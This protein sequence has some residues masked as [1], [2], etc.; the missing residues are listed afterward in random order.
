MV[1]NGFATN[2]LRNLYKKILGNE[3]QFLTTVFQ[4]GVF[5]LQQRAD[6]GGCWLIPQCSSR[7]QREGAHRGP[8]H[9]RKRLMS[10]PR[11]AG[12]KTTTQELGRF[13]AE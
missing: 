12:E 3:G 4:S 8:T 2:N 6:C 5:G 7:C 1:L 11:T 13:Q 9:S 10:A